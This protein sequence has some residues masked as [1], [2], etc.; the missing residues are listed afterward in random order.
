MPYSRIVN[1]LIKATYPVSTAKARMPRIRPRS[2][3]IVTGLRL[4]HAPKALGW[5]AGSSEGESLMPS[6]HGSDADQDRFV[7]VRVFM[8]VHSPA[9]TC[10]SAAGLLPNHYE[11]RVQSIRRP[12]PNARQ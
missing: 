6:P 7:P 3:L 11:T 2:S 8:I 10:P 12:R 1:R 9:P 5:R 4:S